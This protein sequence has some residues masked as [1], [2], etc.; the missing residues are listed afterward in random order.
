METIKRKQ[1]RYAD[2]GEHEGSRQ[3]G[4]RPV[5]ILQNDTGNKYSSTTLVAPLTSNTNRKGYPVHVELKKRDYNIKYNSMVLCEQIT[6][7]DK[8]R[9]K[10]KID[11]LSDYHMKK[12]DVAIKISLGL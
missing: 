5:V 1:I 7:L 9:I 2:L 4:L 10:N 11:D 6:T 12:I 8:S 3:G